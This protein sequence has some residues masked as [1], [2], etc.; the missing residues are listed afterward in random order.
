MPAISRTSEGNNP[1]LY[2]FRSGRKIFI[3]MQ[4]YQCTFFAT[5]HEYFIK[6][7]ANPSYWHLAYLTLPSLEG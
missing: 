4:Q 3:A 1:K 2:Q 5:V 6:G 7:L